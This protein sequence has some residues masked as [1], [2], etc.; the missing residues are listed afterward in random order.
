MRITKFGHACVRIDHEGQV[1]VLDPGV[2]T[3]PEA[4]DGATAVLVTHLHPDH[5]HPANLR[6]THAPVFTVG[7]VAEQLA[8][9]APDV[10]ERTTT[11]PAGA[12]F[13]VGGPA[14]VPVRAVGELHN[15]IHP[16]LP[17]PYNSGY[18]MTFGDQVV[19]HPGD[20]LALPEV[21]VDVL[22]CPSSAPWLRSEMAIEFVRAVGAPRNL[23]IHDRVYTEVGHGML[24]TQMETLVGPR[25]QEWLRIADGAD[26]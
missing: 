22:L 16:E 7:Q 17:Q 13:S 4:V 26:L 8:T 23:A 11:V 5:L 2:F 20:A 12:A 6:A 9:D 24:A 1:V 21:P 19:Y 14:G 3:D 15:V 10:A 18:L 25:G